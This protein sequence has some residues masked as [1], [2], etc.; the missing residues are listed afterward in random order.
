MSLR[1]GI[2]NY[3]DTNAAPLVELRTGTVDVAIFFFS[4]GDGN[5]LGLLPLAQQIRDARSMIGVN[6]CSYDASGQ[7]PPTVEIMA[8]RS[9]SA[10][11]S[12][13]PRG[14][15]HIVGYSFGGLIALEV[16]RLLQDSGETVAILG[17]IDTLFDQRFWPSSVFLRSQ[18]ELIARHLAKLRQLPLRQMMT[19]LVFR[20][21]GFLRRL[22]N[23]HLSNSTAIS[24]R[25]IGSANLIEDHCKSVMGKFSPRPVTGRIICFDAE[26]HDDYG[27]HPAELWQSIGM[28]VECVTISGT[29]VGVIQNDSSLATLARA[30][31]ASLSELASEGTASR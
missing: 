7:L 10:I 17:L 14:P 30:L 11:R 20:C 1:H 15:Y 6:F 29:H 16:T 4:G 13:Q 5:C 25:Q 27:C 9:Y 28:K 22:A 2:S 23:R 19:T 21:R 18:V 26:N 12:M 31:E 8:S 3:A 24:K